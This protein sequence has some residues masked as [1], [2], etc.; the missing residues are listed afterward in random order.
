MYV[1][2]FVIYETRAGQ[3]RHALTHTHYTVL[4][5]RLKLRHNRQL[6]VCDLFFSND[7]EIISLKQ[8]VINVVV[9]AIDVAKYTYI[10]V[11]IVKMKRKPKKRRKKNT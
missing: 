10:Y 2:V 9:V 6:K 7:K 8:C 5:A 1:N 4:L 11:Y 3:S